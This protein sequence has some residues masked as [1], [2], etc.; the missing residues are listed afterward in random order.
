MDIQTINLADKLSLVDA[1][2]SPRIIA[3]MNDYHFKLAKIQGEFI[4][5]AHPETD[6][7]FVVLGGTMCIE[8]RDS[9]TELSEGEM[10]VVP[11]GVEHRPVARKECHI[12][13]IEPAGTLNTGDAGGERTV[14]EEI[15]I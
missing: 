12:M 9:R 7:V 1:Y 13:L 15:W 5:H 14:T 6:E 10:C 8:F 11:R 3:Q 2:W 4:W